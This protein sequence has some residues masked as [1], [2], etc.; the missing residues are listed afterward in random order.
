[1]LTVSSLYH[2]LATDLS[3]AD[4]LLVRMP[5]PTKSQ[6]YQAP[7]LDKAVSHHALDHAHLCLDEIPLHLL[8]ATVAIEDPAFY[9][10][11]ND[12]PATILHD[13]FRNTQVDRIRLGRSPLTRHVARLI[14]LSQDEC[15]VHTTACK[16][17]E[18]LLAHRLARRWTRDAILEAYLNETC[19]G[20]MAY[21]V[22]AAAYLY[23]GV[24]ARDL[25][26]AQ[27]TLLA[28]LPHIAAAA[29]PLASLEAAKARQKIVLQAM[30]HQAYISQF[31]ADLAYVELLCFAVHPPLSGPQSQ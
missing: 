6:N 3:D 30:V 8:Q 7:S 4:D 17:H 28:G 23:F 31:E 29:N 14:L 1:M 18:A 5:H 25:N 27:C 24:H 9:D 16:L 11:S 26:L 21:G 22:E 10:N 19:Y 13:T 12:G 20:K 2:A 15:A